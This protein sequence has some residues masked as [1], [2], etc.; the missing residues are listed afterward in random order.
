MLIFY[1]L[2]PRGLKLVPERKNVAL[3]QSRAKSESG[4]LPEKKGTNPFQ[5]RV[6]RLLRVWNGCIRPQQRICKKVKFSWLQ[7]VTGGILFPAVKKGP[8]VEWFDPAIANAVPVSH[9]QHLYP[10]LS[11]IPCQECKRKV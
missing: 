7:W 3:E 11:A 6:R 4:K 10:Y 5:A 2:D 1:V 8:V 9:A